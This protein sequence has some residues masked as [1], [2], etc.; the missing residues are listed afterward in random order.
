MKCYAINT[1]V[2]LKVIIYQLIFTQV[3][4]CLLKYATA[5]LLHL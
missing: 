4:K 1:V 5:H 2:K 3:Y